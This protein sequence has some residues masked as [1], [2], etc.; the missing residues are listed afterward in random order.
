MA[1]YTWGSLENASP[2]I[3]RDQQAVIT[4]IYYQ[5]IFN[6]LQMALV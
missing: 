2:T 1:F 6:G 5:A 4:S 3:L